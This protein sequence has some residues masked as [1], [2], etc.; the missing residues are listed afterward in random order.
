MVSFV[1]F[2]D[3]ISRIEMRHVGRVFFS[4]IKYELSKIVEIHG[5]GCVGK[6]NV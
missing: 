1:S 4:I 6:M 5:L 2:V 3:L